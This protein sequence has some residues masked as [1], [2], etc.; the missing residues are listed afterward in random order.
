VNATDG[1][2]ETED[3]VAS[4]TEHENNQTNQ[5]ESCD[6]S[7]IDLSSIF[8]P[9]SSLSAIIQAAAEINASKD[10]VRLP[11]STGHATSSQSH[12]S[13]AYFL[14]PVRSA[15]SHA[16][17]QGSTILEHA[18]LNA[19]DDRDHGDGTVSTEMAQ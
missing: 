4:I 1:D 11:S 10:D 9:L 3:D 15:S 13:N 8:I 6:N 14:R 12:L 18:R 19:D 16:N 17:Y 2:S 7:T 5:L